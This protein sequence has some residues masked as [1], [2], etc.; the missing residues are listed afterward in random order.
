LLQSLADG[1]STRQV[2]GERTGPHPEGSAWLVLP[3]SRLNDISSIASSFSFLDML[4]MMAVL[5]SNLSGLDWRG[6]NDAALECPIG[7]DR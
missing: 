3:V 7:T 4:A 2:S 6:V 5:Q 1:C